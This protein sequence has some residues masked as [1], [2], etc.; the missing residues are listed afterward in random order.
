MPSELFE[1]ERERNFVD[2]DLD[3]ERRKVRTADDTSIWCAWVG[4]GS[5]RV[6]PSLP[7]EKDMVK[8]L[9]CDV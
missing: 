4:D 5:A 2:G 6:P 1:F 8:L 9:E 7:W 3:M